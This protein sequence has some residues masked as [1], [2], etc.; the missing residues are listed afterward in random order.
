MRRE[1]GASHKVEGQLCLLDELL[2]H[3]QRKIGVDCTE[4]GDEVV[5]EGADS[6]LSFVASVNLGRHVLDD[7]TGDMVKAVTLREVSLSIVSYVGVMPYFWKK[8]VPCA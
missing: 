4:H 6:A 3:V 8:S 7:D 5:L 1:W 2:E